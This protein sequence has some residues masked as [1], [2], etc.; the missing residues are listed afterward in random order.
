VDI[1]VGRLQFIVLLT[2]NY[3]TFN[4]TI[5]RVEGQSCVRWIKYTHSMTHTHRHKHKR[6]HMAERVWLCVRPV[7][8]KF[9]W[10]KATLAKD[11]HPWIP[12][13]FETAILA[14][15]CTCILI[16]Y[17]YTLFWILWFQGQKSSPSPREHKPR[18]ASLTL[19]QKQLVSC[20]I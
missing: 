3:D 11:R 1:T 18:S 19:S 15:D 5:M 8:Q 9:N 17:L 16:F 6:A 4:I 12:T 14:I 7:A 20:Y 10:Q 2:F 13:G